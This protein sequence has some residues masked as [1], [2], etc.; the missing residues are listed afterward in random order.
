MKIDFDPNCDHTRCETTP[1]ECRKFRKTVKE[2]LIHAD[3][4]F[5]L[6][7]D[8][9]EKLHDK[10]FEGN[11]VFL[12]SELLELSAISALSSNLNTLVSNK[13]DTL[14]KSILE[15]HKA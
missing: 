4:I 3:H 5:T 2:K 13:L 9:F 8:F 14:S 10:S 15:P 7:D 6:C 11:T 1:E 12:P